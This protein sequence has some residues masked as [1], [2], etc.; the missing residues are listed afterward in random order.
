MTGPA[1]HFF[2]NANVTT[3]KQNQFI[4]QTEWCEFGTKSC[5]F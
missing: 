2:F 5:E 4:F 1:I 3:G